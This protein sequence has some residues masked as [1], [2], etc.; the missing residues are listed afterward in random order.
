MHLIIL[1]ISVQLL[2]Y[3]IQCFTLPIGK[4]QF[5]SGGSDDEDDNKSDGQ[6]QQDDKNLHQ[7]PQQ[8]ATTA[9]RQRFESISDYFYAP[10]KQTNSRVDK[11]LTDRSDCESLIQR[12]FSQNLKIYQKGSKESDFNERNFDEE[13]GEETYGGT[14][15]GSSHFGPSKYYYL[16]PPRPRPHPTSYKSGKC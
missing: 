11:L 9:R 1:I 3:R 13:F 8:Q 2:L 16:R 4:R 5:E 14:I 7:L 12:I 6:D 10:K 15:G